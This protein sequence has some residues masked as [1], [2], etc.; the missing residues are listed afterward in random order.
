VVTSVRVSDIS[1]QNLVPSCSIIE[2]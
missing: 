1:E 2:F